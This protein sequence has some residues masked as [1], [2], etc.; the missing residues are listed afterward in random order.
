ME[1]AGCTVDFGP[2]EQENRYSSWW[3]PGSWHPW[4][5]NPVAEIYLWIKQPDDTWLGLH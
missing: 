4:I 3:R 1:M 5:G 2:P